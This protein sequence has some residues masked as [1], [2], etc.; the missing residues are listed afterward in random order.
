MGCPKKNQT[1]TILDEQ[2]KEE[3]VI[4]FNELEEVVDGKVKE[5]DVPPTSTS[6]A[7]NDYVLGLLEPMDFQENNPTVDGLRRV[8]RLLIG[9]IVEEFPHTVACREDFAAVEYTLVFD[10]GVRV[11]AVA[12]SHNNN[13]QQPPYSFYHLAVAETRA[14]GRALRKVLN[15]RK[16][17]SAEELGQTATV[18]SSSFLNPISGAQLKVIEKLCKQLGIDSMKLI[19]SGSKVFNTIEEVSQNEALELIKLLNRYQGDSNNSEHLEIPD[20]IKKEK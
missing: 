6:L 7:W 12:D 15:L 19:N 8:A 18:S 5:E 11:G 20:N 4:P 10:N 13:N 14:M 17:V 9:E 2:M 3:E 1:E 16:V